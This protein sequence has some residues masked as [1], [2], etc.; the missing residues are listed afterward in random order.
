MRRFKHLSHTDRLRIETMQ[1]DGKTPREMADRVGVHIS[2]IY[3]ELKRGV[4]ERLN[5]DYTTES[6][7]SPEIAEE[8][9]RANLLAKG[10]ALK[11]GADHELAKYIENRILKDDYYPAAVLGEIRRSPDLCFKT[12]ISEMTLYS[13]IDKGV[14]LTLTNKNLP[15]KRKK[16]RGYHKVK[17]ARPPKGE[18]IEKR[19]E[20]INSRSTFG[21]WEMDSVEGKQGTKP[22]LLVLTER[23]TRQEI[24]FRVPDGTAASVV[25]SL[26][27]LERKYGKEMFK[28]VFQTITVDNGSE[29]A[30]YTGMERSR[31][32]K[33]KRTTVYYCHPYS[34][35][36][37][38]S[39]EN[40]NKM[41]RR[42]FPKGSS[43]EKVTAGAVAAAVEWLNNYPREIFDFASSEELFRERVAALA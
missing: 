42:R 31:T 29:F 28:R 4:Y 10:P 9:Y 27:N 26:D 16:K 38:G 1:R 40:Q 35:Y 14:F 32:G 39:N 7:Y 19:P 21:H 33:G 18:S 3:R 36:E 5:S 20:E 22:R 30:D 24:V 37:R 41:L 23:L 2:T 12:S 13:Y 43:F 11:I 6:R 17:A 25:K 34:S 15:V 8:R